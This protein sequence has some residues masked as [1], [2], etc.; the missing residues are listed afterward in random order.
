MPSPRSELVK[1]LAVPR[2]DIERGLP[3]VRVIHELFY[4]YDQFL[5]GMKRGFP[6]SERFFV[7]SAI[8]KDGTAWVKTVVGKKGRESDLKD[9]P[10]YRAIVPFWYSTQFGN[11]A[12]VMQAIKQ[13]ISSLTHAERERQ[14]LVDEVVGVAPYLEMRQDKDGSGEAGNRE[15]GEAINAEVTAHD[16]SGLN[17]LAVLG[18]HS[19]EGVQYLEKEGIEVLPITAAPLFAEHLN[20]HVFVR[21][22]LSPREQKKRIDRENTRI[23]ALDKGSLQQCVHLAELLDMDPADRI[24]AFDK[25]RK[26]HNMVADSALIYGDPQDL[27]D[28][29]IIIYDDII[30]TFGSMQKTCES[31][32]KLYKCRSITVMAT[33]G[34]LSHPGRQNIIDALEPNGN[35]EKVIDRV[36]LTDSLLRAKYGF[37]KQKVKGLSVLNVAEMLGHLAHV[38]ADS[39]KEDMLKD[40][41]YR[42]FILEPIDKEEVWNHFKQK[43]ARP[44]KIDWYHEV[45]EDFS[46]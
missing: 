8:F 3:E 17:K 22:G 24:V 15:V 46:I 43:H 7:D 19:F 5:D 45:Y 34:V 37:D 11:D 16:L 33:H 18:P 32:K 9:L 28:R 42:Q 25:K 27:V 38:F 40:E 21:E 2:I 30:D 41:F 39:S 23:V 31:L 13:V 35:H 4:R 10:R 6:N 12:E 20:E 26:G 14:P 1:Q 29:D 36:I 44:E